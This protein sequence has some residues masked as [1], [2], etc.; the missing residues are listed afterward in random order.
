M[1]IQHL[2]Y[3]MGQRVLA[4]FPEIAEVA[5]E[6]QNRLW[7]TVKVSDGDPRT[8]VYSDPRPAH[9]VIGLTLRR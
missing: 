1:S 9:G 7:D 8:R 6:A 5:F 2:V 4:D 3:Q